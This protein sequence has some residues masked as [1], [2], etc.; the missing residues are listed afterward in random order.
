MISILHYFHPSQA[1]VVPPFPHCPPVPG[2]LHCLSPFAKSWHQPKAAGNFPL[3]GLQFRSAALSG[4]MGRWP[5]PHGHGGG[6]YPPTHNKGGPSGGH[7][8][9]M[10]R[11]PGKAA[12]RQSLLAA[13]DT[14][15][16]SYACHV[17]S[18]TQRERL[19]RMVCEQDVS[20]AGAA[21]GR[22]ISGPHPGTAYRGS[23]CAWRV[24]LPLAAAAA[25]AIPPQE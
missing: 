18:K 22:L 3:F 1:G 9:R 8:L 2:S 13:E 25:A 21:A 24:P 10:R 23:P 17:V 19:F 5:A 14:V 7:W 20:Q 15:W 6:R 11:P 12:R 16:L 4:S